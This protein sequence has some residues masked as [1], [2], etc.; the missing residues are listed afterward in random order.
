[1]SKARNVLGV[2]SCKHQGS[3]M[4]VLGRF[5]SIIGMFL[6]VL[7]VSAQPPAQG[8]NKF[9]GNITTGG[10]I[11]NDFLQ[12]WNQIT[13]ENEHKWGSIE[14]SRGNRNWNGGDRIANFANEN[15]ILWKFHTLVWGSQEPGWVRGSNDLTAVTDWM[16]A[17]QARYPDVPMIDVV[18]EAENG[19]APAS[20]KGA[21]GGDGA[22]G[23]DW[24]IKSF[25]LARERWPKAILI[26]NDYNN[27]EYGT[28]VNWTY[29]LVKKMI[30]VGAPIDAIGCQAHDAFKI[31]TS[32]LKANLDQLAS[33][34]LP[35]FI[36]E[37]DIGES[38]DSRQK[39]IME[40]Q[41]TMMWN[42]PKIVGITY[43]GYI[44]G[45]TWRTGTGLMEQSG[46]ERPALTWLKQYVKD[47]PN[48]PNDFPDLL[49]IGGGG[50]ANP[51]LSF[52]SKGQGEV[53][54]SSE[55]TSFEKDTKVTLTAKASE[56]WVFDSWSGDATGKDNPLELTM[57]ASKTI[58]AIFKTVDGKEDMVTNGTFSSGASGWSFNNWGGAGSGK[59]ENGEYKITVETV[60]EEYFDIQAVQPGITLEKGKIYRLEFEAYA[61]AARSLYVNMGMP[62]SPYTS[63]FDGVADEKKIVDLT[64][65]KQKYTIDFEM[66]EATY[67][68]SRIEFS[69]A[70]EKASVFID[71]VSLFECADCTDAIAFAAKSPKPQHISISQKGLLVNININKM[72]KNGS[73]VTIYDML[74]NVVRT[75]NIKAN[76]GLSQYS[77]HIG[78]IPRGYYIVAVRNGN[79]FKTSKIISMGK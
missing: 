50:S 11:R 54:S 3:S 53:T 46:A 40:E 51:R 76:S 36:T 60:S 49:S 75:E 58:V 70:L 8:A 78:N 31:S 20:Y 19:H 16:D 30:E 74:G 56:G 59:V 27:C 52:S 55:E 29:N 15:G 25:E 4:S 48:P 10:Q 47:N 22:T 65:A 13:G 68:D 41:F 67:E 24:I 26:Y 7:N 37:Y 44:V 72:E 1:M 14:G 33:L 9:L 77:L 2:V 6:I 62:E 18:N 63:F 12:Y 43:W 57:D 73:L 66:T 38:N 21:L 64:T 17:A 45:R 32:S 71:N 28:S 5:A 61:S 39:Q 69:A 23:Y 34:G 35:I 42:H 79:M